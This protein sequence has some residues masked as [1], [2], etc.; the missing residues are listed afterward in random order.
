MRTLIL[1]QKGSGWKYSCKQPHYSVG[2]ADSF[3]PFSV[4]ISARRT[5]ELFRMKSLPHT[6]RRQGYASDAGVFR[7]YVYDCLVISSPWWNACTEKN[8][9]DEHCT[10]GYS[11]GM[12]VAVPNSACR[13]LWCFMNVSSPILTPLVQ[14]FS[15]AF[16]CINGPKGV[17]AAV[18]RLASCLTDCATLF[19]SSS[20]IT[21]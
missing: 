3:S 4:C 15:F 17:S 2:T 20:S 10:Q 5:H 6:Q 14:P 18:W 7:I 11:T 19:C 8:V 21:H 9:T 16:L 12:K 1:R 13:L